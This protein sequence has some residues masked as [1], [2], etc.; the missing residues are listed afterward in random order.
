[1]ICT[2]C[3]ASQS[4]GTSVAAQV[5]SAAVMKCLIISLFRV[6]REEVPGRW[7]GTRLAIGSVDAVDDGAIDDEP[8]RLRLPPCDTFDDA[9]LPGILDHDR[10]GHF[11][12]VSLSDGVSGPFHRKQ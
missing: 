3:L 11:G 2:G 12:P 10:V 5:T 4:E 7:P 8:D 1:M 9:A 6:G